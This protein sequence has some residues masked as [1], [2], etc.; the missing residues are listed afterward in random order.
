MKICALML[1]HKDIDSVNRLINKLKCDEIDIYIHV[2]KKSKMDISKIDKKATVLKLRE[3][4]YFADSSQLEATIKS[5][6]EVR[7]NKIYDYYIFLSG[8]DYPIVSSKNI[9]EFFEKNNGKI[10]LN[11]QKLAPEYWN[12]TYRY[13]KIFFKNKYIRFIV[14][15]LPIKLKFIE[16]YL[17]YGGDAWFNLT[18][19]AVDFMIKEYYNKKIYKRVKYMEM[20]EEIIYQSILVNSKLKD[21]IVNNS[22]RYIDWSEHAAGLNIGHPNI[23]T[24]KDYDKIINSGKLFCRK[25]DPNKSKKLMEMLDKNMNKI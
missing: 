8:Q 5:L 14:R 18:D 9:V 21:K 2:D 23:L 10:F 4:V 13:E 1:I 17:P 3:K 11:Y 12:V 22:L 7:K 15:K 24:E 20:P 6:E 19:E 25:I 16:G